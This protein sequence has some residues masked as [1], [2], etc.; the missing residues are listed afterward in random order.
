MS[1]WISISLQ[2]VHLTD[3]LLLKE[4][5]EDIR[6]ALEVEKPDYNTIIEP[7]KPERQLFGVKQED[8]SS[9]NSAASESGSPHCTDGARTD[10]SNVFEPD[11]SD[12]SYV[13]EDEEVRGYHQFLKLEDGAGSFD[14]PV[15]E[16][17]LW[18]WP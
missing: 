10:S 12:I 8:R 1:L 14:F 5:P 6:E 13:E 4:K 17:A 11:Q 15:E 9:S 7:K 18:F 2:V 16:Q 3:K